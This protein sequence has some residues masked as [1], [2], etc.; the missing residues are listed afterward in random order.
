MRNN[1]SGYLGSPELQTSTANQELIPLADAS[2]TSGY[3][4]RKLSF[5]NEQE[6]TVKIID[7]HDKESTHFLKA[8][9]GFEVSYLDPAIKSFVI[10]EAGI[11][12]IWSATY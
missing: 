3:K 4:F 6:C 7:K 11:N 12:F 2:W 5:D 8:G 1:A 10:V 9:Y